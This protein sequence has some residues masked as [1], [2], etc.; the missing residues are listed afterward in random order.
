MPAVPIPEVDLRLVF[1]AVAKYASG[2]DFYVFEKERSHQKSAVEAASKDIGLAPSTIRNRLG[3]GAARYGWKVEDFVNTSRPAEDD[4]IPDG[5]EVL[6]R[7]APINAAYIDS[8]RKKWRRIVPVRHEPFGVAFVG[9]P[10]VENKGADLGKLRRDVETIRASG[11]R[12][13]NMGDVID[14]FHETGKL[15]KLQAKNRMSVSEAYGVARWL[16]RDSGVKWDAHLLGNHDAWGGLAMATMFQQWA[17]EAKTR[18]YDWMAQITY[19]WDGGSY[20]VLAAHDFKGSSIYNPLHGAMKRALEDGT[21]DLYA[22]AHRHNHAKADMPNAF[23]ERH[24]QFVRV[25]GYKAWDDHAHRSGYAQ[26]DEGHSAV[27][28]INPWAETKEGRCRVFHDLSE[29]AE[30]LQTLKR[31]EAA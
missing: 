22:A 3:A 23:R 31:R 5:L 14:N 30:W 9:D 17:S 24:Y 1:E 10:H 28:I 8:S 18:F 20:T 7:H 19:Q 4:D 12:A 13:I 27:A 2:P 16:I 21:A 6:N 29:G 26:A 11:F 25:A 15:A